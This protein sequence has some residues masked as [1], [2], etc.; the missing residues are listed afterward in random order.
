[1]KWKNTKKDLFRLSSLLS[2]DPGQP[3]TGEA[4]DALAAT[5]QLMM[6]YVVAHAHG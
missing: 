3:E 1:M 5:H 4:R 6:L 2:R